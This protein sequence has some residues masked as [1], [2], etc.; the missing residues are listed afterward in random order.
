MVLYHSRTSKIFLFPSLIWKK[1]FKTYYSDLKDNL[2]SRYLFYKIKKSTPLFMSPTFSRKRLCWIWKPNRVWKI[3]SL[4][5]GQVSM[6]DKVVSVLLKT[7]SIT[8]P[9]ILMRCYIYDRDYP[10]LQNH[11]YCQFLPFENYIPWCLIPRF[12]HIV[13]DRQG[14]QVKRFCW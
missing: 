10:P 1:K 5:T 3:V 12:W 6:F 2:S 13:E 7:W 14:C 8:K 11:F 9:H 4:F